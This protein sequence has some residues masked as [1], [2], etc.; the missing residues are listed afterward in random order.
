MLH[1]NPVYNTEYRVYEF[2]Q[3]SFKVFYMNI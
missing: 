2:P 1:Q 3:N